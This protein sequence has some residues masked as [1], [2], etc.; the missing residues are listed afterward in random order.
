MLKIFGIT[1]GV[2]IHAVFGVMVWYLYWFLKGGQVEQSA[3]ALW[4]DF[5]LALQ[6]VVVHSLLLHPS[7]REPLGEW[8]TPA[9]Y[10][11]FYCVATI[12]G[13]AITMAFWHTSPGVWWELTGPARAA[14]DA[15]FYGSWIL[16]FYSFF[17]NGIGYQTGFTPWWHWIRGRPVPPRSFKPRGVFRIMRHP[18]YLSFLGLVWFTPVMTADRAILTVTWTI[19]VFV[20]SY[21]KDQ[22]LLRYIGEPYRQYM[23]EVPG[24]PG[25]LIGPLGRIPATS[26]GRRLT[27]SSDQPATSSLVH[28]LHE[29]DGVGA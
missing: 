14:I 4:L 29:A 26:C 7:I 3:G 13:L 24:Y 20:G 12:V 23:A 9:F 11:L 17:L 6:F 5:V 16:L 10:G 19:Y 27:S 2:L 8:I 28:H 15:G 22:R 18:S 25:M 21:L 1:A